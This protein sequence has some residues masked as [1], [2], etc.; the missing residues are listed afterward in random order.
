MKM[1]QLGTANSA[2]FGVDSVTN[3]KTNSGPRP[4]L[5]LFPKP[6]SNGLLRSINNRSAFNCCHFSAEVMLFEER[7][8]ISYAA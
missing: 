5:I 1:K 6:H 7:T 2:V 8:E 4:A 3:V